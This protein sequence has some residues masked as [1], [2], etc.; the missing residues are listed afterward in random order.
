MNAT[1]RKTRTTIK[2]E[3]K[4]TVRGLGKFLRSTEGTIIMTIAAVIAMVVLA[5]DFTKWKHNNYVTD[6]LEHCEYVGDI[7]ATIE[8]DDR[9]KTVG[10]IVDH[11][12]VFRC[13]D[14]ALVEYYVRD[15]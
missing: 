8:R 6:L 2:R 12:Q 14:G 9:R 1:I 7:G 10:P 13:Q 4:G 5:D 11:R 3:I 15:D